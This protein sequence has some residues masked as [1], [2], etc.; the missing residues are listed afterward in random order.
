MAAHMMGSQRIRSVA[1]TAFALLGLAGLAGGLD[2]PPCLMSAF[3]EVSLRVVL[4]A[5][6]WI[7]S[8]AWQALGPCLFGHSGI[9][10]GLLQV[11]IGN[12]QLILT[13]TGLA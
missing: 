13:F 11:S 8:P 7:I 2:H 5:L 4:G 3:V 10:D 6:S 12:W 1:G 9:L